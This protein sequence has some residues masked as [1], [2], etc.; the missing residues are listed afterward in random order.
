MSFFLDLDS[1][2][3][4]QSTISN[5]PKVLDKLIFKTFQKIGEEIINGSYE[6]RGYGRITGRLQSSYAFVIIKDKRVVYFQEKH[7]ESDPKTYPP[8][9]EEMTPRQQMKEGLGKLVSFLPVKGYFLVIIAAMY[10]GLFVHSTGRMVMIPLDDSPT[11][12]NT[13][14]ILGNLFSEKEIGG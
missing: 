8:G 13:K 14:Q 6:N 11:F 2:R 3:D 7:D 10:Y 5:A 4:Y 9:E 1:Q 12:K